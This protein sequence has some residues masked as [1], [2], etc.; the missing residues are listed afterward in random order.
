MVDSARLTMPL[1][2]PKGDYPVDDSDNASLKQ[3]L[4]K[5]IHGGRDKVLLR[6]ICAYSGIY[7]RRMLKG[8]STSWRASHT[9]HRI[10]PIWNTS[11]APMITLTDRPN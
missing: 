6:L 4:S 5:L 11:I 8:D 3:L 7:A 2:V 1:S 10:S 9:R